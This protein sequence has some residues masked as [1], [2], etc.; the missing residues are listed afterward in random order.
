MGKQVISSVITPA[1][2]YNLTDLATVKTELSI[3]N[4]DTKSD[5]WLS[6]KIAQASSAIQTY[7][8]R[9]FVQETLQDVVY[10]DRA[11]GPYWSLGNFQPLQL[12]RWPVASISSIVV[13]FDANPD[14]NY[15]FVQGLDFVLNGGPG[16]I[17]RLDQA[18]ALP[19]QWWAYPLTVIYVAGYATIPGDLVNATLQL[20]SQYFTARGRDPLTKRT[21]QPG[22]IGEIEY[23]V[24]NTPQGALPQS[25]TDLIDS[26]RAPTF[27]L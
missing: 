26:Y 5:A 18:S 9:T 1:T 12:R 25:V 22:G 19:A 11:D 20:V 27:A 4:T 13:Q 2:S 8:D 21:N 10:P 17:I 24:P 23:W 6:L 16:Q 15:T 3:P 7:C 14:N